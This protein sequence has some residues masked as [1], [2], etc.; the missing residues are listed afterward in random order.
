MAKSKTT[1]DKV[2]YICVDD[3]SIIDDI[4]DGLLELIIKDI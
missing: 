3:N 1:L 2:E 4:L